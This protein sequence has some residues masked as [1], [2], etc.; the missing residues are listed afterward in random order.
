MNMLRS[1]DLN[2]HILG[3]FMLALVLLSLLNAGNRGLGGYDIREV[4]VPE[5]KAMIDAGAAVIDVRDPEQFNAHH[6][7]GAK[8]VELGE[9]QA[10]IPKRILALKTKSIVVY[11]GDGVT[12]GPEGTAIL[13]KAGFTKAVN[14]RPGFDGWQSAGMTLAKG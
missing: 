9:L 7:P 12:H 3:I 11:C 2:K 10:G 13:N 5:A 8:L 6:I 1:F 14:L 4:S